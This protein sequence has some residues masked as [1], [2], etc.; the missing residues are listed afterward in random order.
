MLPHLSFLQ[1]T[2]YETTPLSSRMPRIGWQLF[3]LLNRG[4]AIWRY[5]RKIELYQTPGKFFELA[6]GHA[7]RFV[8]GDILIV[9]LA[10]QALLIA[11]RVLECVQQQ[12]AFCREGRKWKTALSGVYPQRVRY[13]AGRQ[14]RFGW[15]SP[16]FVC[17]VKSR[18]AWIVARVQKMAHHTFKLFKRL[19]RLSMGMLDAMDALCLNPQTSQD[20]V[21]EC[22]VNLVKWVDAIAKNK[23]ELLCGLERNKEVI[24]RLLEYSKVNY[25]QFYAGVLKTVQGTEVL[26]KKAKWLSRIEKETI[27]N[28]GARLLRTSRVVV[29]L[30]F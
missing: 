29:G 22:V 26:R 16:S 21:N 6:A 3:G 9:R 30:K 4:H 8:A 24:Q 1:A 5:Y 7:V 17:S 10:A 19:F 20:A 28:I 15:L 12:A 14:N 25:E 23:E 18:Y 13:F 27:Q 11:T 2:I